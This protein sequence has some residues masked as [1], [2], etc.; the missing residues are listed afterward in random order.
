MPLTILFPGGVEFCWTSVCQQAFEKIGVFDL[1]RRYT[2][3]SVYD[4]KVP[5]EQWLAAAG[6]RN[7]I[8]GDPSQY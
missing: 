8:A 2:E 7:R 6:C 4:I 1:K 3:C 5:R